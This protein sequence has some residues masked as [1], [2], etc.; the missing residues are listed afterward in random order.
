M[1]VID[2]TKDF[3]KKNY[4]NLHNV[5]AQM[6]FSFISIYPS[7]DFGKN[8]R[9][10]N[11]VTVEDFCELG[12]NVLVGNGTVIRPET[13]IGANSRIGHCCVLEGNIKIGDNCRIQ[14]NC[15][16]TNG[17]RIGNKVLI[18]PGFI[19]VNDNMLC[20]ENMR[21]DA[22]WQQLPFEILDGA[23]IGAGS[24]INAGVVIG[25]NAF[26]ATGSVVMTRVQDNEIVRGNPA[27]V[28][29]IVPK[30]ERI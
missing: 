7:V 29:G 14:S 17:A 2:T 9:L 16:I 12:D 21:P 23:R 20:H 26:V 5:E 28:I 4:L 11:F 15:H 8:V 25:R 10:G 13:I 1:K 18:A 24:I 27:K 22:K 6:G 19:G 30:I 3:I